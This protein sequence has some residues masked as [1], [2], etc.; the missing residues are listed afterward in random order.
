[1]ESNKPVIIDSGS[2]VTKIGRGGGESPSA[3]FPTCV[4]RARFTTMKETPREVLLKSLF[5]GSEAISRREML[6]IHYPVQHGVNTDL[7]DLSKL[8][9]YCY[10]EQLKAERTQHPAL[11]VE[12]PL[13]PEWYREQNMAI[14]L[15]EFE[16]PSFYLA[17]QVVLPL[18]SIGKTTGVVLSSGEGVTDTV[19]VY[20]GH[21][22]KHTG[23]R[24]FLEG[25]TLSNRLSELIKETGIDLFSSKQL[26][27]SWKIKEVECYVALNF[28]EELTRFKSEG[29]KKVDYK[30]P[31][32]QTIRLGEELI[33]TPEVLFKPLL[34]GKDYLKDLCPIRCSPLGVHEHALQVIEKSDIDLRRE[35]FNNIVISGGNTCLKGFYERYKTEVESLAPGNMKVGVISS[36]DRQCSAWIGGSILSQ[37][38]SFQTWWVTRQEYEECG[39]GLVHRKC[40]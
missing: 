18:Y 27:H 32:G 33:R 5:F 28:E 29:W 15:E 11:L 19:A 12:A 39:M 10:E 7:D 9:K 40:F 1:M 36:N 24:S 23:K 4:G 16:V 26:H 31:D 35:L 30:L 6:A 25:R 20:E 38:S 14:F 37:L 3:C 8:W 22:I 34:M 17:N 13:S 21:L 2:G